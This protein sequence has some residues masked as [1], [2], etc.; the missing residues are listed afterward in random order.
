MQQEIKKKFRDRGVFC[1]DDVHLPNIGDITVE[2]SDDY[3]S[4]LA[5]LWDIED[6]IATLAG[7]PNYKL[8]SLTQK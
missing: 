3:K 5:K 4:V 8:R 7:V 2:Q 1:L 6:A